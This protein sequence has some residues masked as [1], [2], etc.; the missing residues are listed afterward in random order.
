MKTTLI[1]KAI[2]VVLACSILAVFLVPAGLASRNQVASAGPVSACNGT[3]SRLKVFPHVR[4]NTT[5]KGSVAGFE[6]HISDADGFC[7]E[8][9]YSSLD[10]GYEVDLGDP[11]DSI[12][13]GYALR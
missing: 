11:E 4:L 10:G 6:I 5:A 3:A 8:M 13:G 12:D 9:V 2:S 7:S 1:A